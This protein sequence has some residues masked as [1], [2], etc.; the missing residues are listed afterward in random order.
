MNPD[1]ELVSNDQIVAAQNELREARLKLENAIFT[2]E[3]ARTKLNAALEAVDR[4]R[5]ELTMHLKDEEDAKEALGLWRGIL[6]ANDQ[7]MSL[8]CPSTGRLLT[9]SKKLGPRLLYDPASNRLVLSMA[10]IRRK[11]ASQMLRSR[12]LIKYSVIERRTA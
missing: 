8:M 7:G 2:S 12:S 11:K 5:S 6:L 4:A 9:I 10:L 1:L 3:I